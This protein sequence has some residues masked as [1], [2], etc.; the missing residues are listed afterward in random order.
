[1]ITLPINKNDK[2]VFI[3]GAGAS[4]DDEI[5]NQNK[6]L[7]KILS[8]RK[9]YRDRAKALLDSLFPYRGDNIPSLE[10]L[11]N[12]LETAI[13]KKSAIGKLNYNEIVEQRDLLIKAIMHSVKKLGNASKYDIFKNKPKS[14]YTLF[15][16]KIYEFY[17]NKKEINSSIVT[18]NYDI[19]IDRVLFTMMQNERNDIYID[20]G[21][22][23]GSYELNKNHKYYFAK[24]GK[25]KILLLRP[26]GSLNWLLCRSC[27][28]VFTTKQ[29]QVSKRKMDEKFK[30]FLCDIGL[31]S[32]YI[33]H[34]S[35]D[36]SYNVPFI[37]TIWE[38]LENILVKANKWCFI[39]Y[40]FSDTDRYFQYI[41]KRAYMLR[42]S[43][44]ISPEIFVVDID[45]KDYKFNE[46]KDKY[47][48][49][50]PIPDD[51][52]YDKG[53]MEFTEKIIDFQ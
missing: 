13:E 10:T 46:L 21:V 28:K 45:K 51:N 47:K 8:G 11:F 27:G 18:F 1:M 5:P 34:P 16:K 32:P 35:Y 9:Y 24:P 3:M 40:S 52:F 41:L 31:L 15:G 25:R 23:L 12:L 33:I 19:C 42:H 20:M 50:F 38:N 7:E 37:A 48:R 26:H 2:V 44:D 39:G 6:I 49:F 14:P 17:K 36:R 53:F 4:F 30:C 43:K 29:F 22:N